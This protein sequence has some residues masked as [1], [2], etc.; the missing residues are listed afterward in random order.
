MVVVLAVGFA[1]IAIIA[2]WLKRRHDAKM[3]RLYEPAPMGSNSALFSNQVRDPSL[4]GPNSQGKA[5]DSYYIAP[6]STDSSTISGTPGMRMTPLSNSSRYSPMPHRQPY[7]GS[8]DL[9]IR[10]VPR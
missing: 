2:V 7:V 5:G 9:E 8:Q 6:E 4:A 1:I 10:E 3:A